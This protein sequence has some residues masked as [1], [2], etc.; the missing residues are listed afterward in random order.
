MCLASFKPALYLPTIFNVEWACALNESFNHNFLLLQKIL[1]IYLINTLLT[2]ETFYKYFSQDL[3]S[4]CKEETSH[5][6]PRSQFS[7]VSSIDSSTAAHSGASSLAKY[8][9]VESH[10]LVSIYVYT[11][12][13]YHT[14][15][16]LSGKSRHM[17]AKTNP[18]ANKNSPKLQVLNIWLPVAFLHVWCT[19]IK[20]YTYSDF[21]QT[22]EGCLYSTSGVAGGQVRARITCQSLSRNISSN[23]EWKGKLEKS[24]PSLIFVHICVNLSRINVYF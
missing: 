9:R 6:S 13:I 12:Y 21:S 19:Y 17:N 5:E 23:S 8:F 2:Q 22:N 18:K 1:H 20:H 15:A 3:E 14:A 24:C 16:P 10:I 11:L 4:P 7:W